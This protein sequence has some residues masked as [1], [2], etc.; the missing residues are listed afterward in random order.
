MDF[1]LTD[2]QQAVA[3][4]AGTILAERSTPARLDQ[5]DAR[6]EWLDRELQSD[7]AAAGML[8]IALPEAHGGGG[9]DFLALHLVLTEL[10]ATTAHVPLWE[11]VVLGALP[12][13]AFGTPEQQAGLLPG[14]IDGTSILTAALVEDGRDDPR[15]PA[16]RAVEVDGGWRLD[17]SRT[18]VPCGQLADRIL[19]PARTDD[20]GIGLFLVDPTVAGVELRP[21]ESISGRPHA[22]VDLDGVA[23]DAADVLGEVATHGGDRLDWVVQRARS[24]LASMQVG[25]TRTAL[26]MSAR[27]TSEREQFG[28]KIGSFQAVGQRVADAFIDCEGIRLTAL[29]AAWRLS[30]GV[31]AA[32]A[33]A[34]AAWWAAE[35]AH[36]VVHAAQHVHG[37]V[38]IDFDYPLHRYFT[39]A[40]EIEFTLGHA[41]AQLLELG[42]RMAVEPV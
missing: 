18:R 20:G 24:G 22:E 10:G 5:L 30:R 21:Q 13:A 4:L 42:R 2:E 33:V 15:T 41:T 31:D 3:E 1:A 23:L 28:R 38:G 32:D 29:Q 6:G 16:V 25:V 11:S 36:R 8:G 9:L 17:G 37:G 27:Y 34:I 12:V 35:G 26:E 19:V 7:L 39:A 14:V 40:K